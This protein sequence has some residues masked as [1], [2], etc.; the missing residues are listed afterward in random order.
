[1]EQLNHIDRMV[2]YDDMPDMFF[3]RDSVPNW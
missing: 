3:K 1:M 2:Q